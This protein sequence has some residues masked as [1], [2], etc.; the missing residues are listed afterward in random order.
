MYSITIFIEIGY[1]G[2]PHR[3][4][5]SFKPAKTV[6]QVVNLRLRHIWVV[7]PGES[8]YMLD[9]KI[10]AL[11]LKQVKSIEKII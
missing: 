6:S 3:R 2:L 1:L 10:T 8:N 9:K 4:E 7:Y 11:P 5:H